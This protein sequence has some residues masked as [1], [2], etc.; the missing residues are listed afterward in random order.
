M[1]MLNRKDVG[2]AGLAPVLVAIIGIGLVFATPAVAGEIFSWKT[3]N[4]EVAFTDN[5]K[6][7]PARYRSQVQ[8]R[9]SERI[10]DYAKFSSGQPEAT[11]RYAEQLA[12]RLDYLRWLNSDRE[13]AD[14][15][16]DALNG[17]AS[18][19]VHG[20]DLRLP[21]ADVDAPII[22]EN[23]RVLGD[24]QITTRHDAVVRQGGRTLAIVRGRQEGEVGSASNILDEK[25]LEF[26]R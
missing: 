11:N 18:I 19:N 2:T 23:L 22:V 25:D 15:A 3:E 4:G 14:V 10:E 16:P 24:G 1:L 17:V 20:I 26:Y 8:T 9:A 13:V 21:G 7:I 12:S 6:K 5:P